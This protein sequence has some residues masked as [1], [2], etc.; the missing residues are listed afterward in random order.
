MAETTFLIIVKLYADFII[1]T[2]NRSF[3]REQRGD[4]KYRKSSKKVKIKQNF[5]YYSK[6]KIVQILTKNDVYNQI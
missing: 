6:I 5:F 2:E 4:K 1:K 3:R